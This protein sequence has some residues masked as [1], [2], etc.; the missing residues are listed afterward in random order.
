MKRTIFASVIGL[1]IIFAS[2]KYWNYWNDYREKELLETF[3][4]NQYKIVQ[5]DFAVPPVEEFPGWYTK[6]EQIIKELT[7]FLDKYQV[8]RSK[9]N[10]IDAL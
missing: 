6:D 2:Y 4:A 5:I 1:I 8:K 10:V 9:E 3:K 7:D